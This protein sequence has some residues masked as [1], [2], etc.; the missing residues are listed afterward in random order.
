[1]CQFVGYLFANM[2]D[3][4]LWVVSTWRF[5]GI[6]ASDVSIAHQHVQQL[7]PFELTMQPSLAAAC[8]V[9]VSFAQQPAD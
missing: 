3:A 9:S 8:V 7:F 2:C 6:L 5:L 1:M 4:V